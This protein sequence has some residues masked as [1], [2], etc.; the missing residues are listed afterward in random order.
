MRRLAVVVIAVLAVVPAARAGVNADRARASLTALDAAF[1][2]TRGTY[3][4]LSEGH[5]AYAWPLSQEVSATLAV[6]AMPGASAGDRKR[7]GADLGILRRYRSGRVYGATAGGPVFDDDNLWIAF[8]LLDWSALTHDATAAVEARRLFGFA[9]ARWD[10]SATGPC[11]GGVYWTLR[12]PNRDR[13]AVT[14]G[15][16]ALLGLRV[17]GAN[18][19]AVR[20]WSRRMLDWLDGCLLGADG[21]YADHIDAAGGLVPRAWSY[22]QGLVIGA[23]ALAAQAG[24]AQA[25]ARAEWLAQASLYFLDPRRLWAE[26]AEFDAVLA[27]NLLLLG[28]VDGDERWRAA[29]Q[30]YADTAWTWTRDPASGLFDLDGTGPRLIEQAALTQIYALLAEP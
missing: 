20:W 6:A 16:A 28:R 7:A 1:R 26:P 11:P 3:V 23:L 5:P 9:V 4:E 10:S 18:D 15:G 29:V 14:T 22:N 2:T 8:D 17:A 24:D 13:N 21:L 30:A 12:G 19:P 25:L 27:R